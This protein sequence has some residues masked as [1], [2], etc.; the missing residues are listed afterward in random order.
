MPN[1][2]DSSLNFET[3][4]IGMWDEVLLLNF[5]IGTALQY[6]IYMIKGFPTTH[7]IL[8]C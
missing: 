5:P 4:L 6:F 1:L 2:C 7:S 3:K 8:L